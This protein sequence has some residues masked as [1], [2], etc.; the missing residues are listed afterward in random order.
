LESLFL[1]YFWFILFFLKNT[2]TGAA[3]S[4]HDYSSHDK[5]HQEHNDYTNNNYPYEEIRRK[6]KEW[7]Y[8]WHDFQLKWFLMFFQNVSI[9]IEMDL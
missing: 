1:Y 7:H 6:S 9:F 5:H 8:K 2:A 3:P 4:P